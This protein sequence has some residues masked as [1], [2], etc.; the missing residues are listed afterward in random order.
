MPNPFIF[1]TKLYYTVTFP[2]FMAAY[3]IYCNH[4]YCVIKV[5]SEGVGHSIKLS[6]RM[7]AFVNLKE[8][9]QLITLSLCKWT[10][11]EHEMESMKFG[12]NYCGV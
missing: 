11:G 12:I 7:I 4:G 3:F 8:A 9:L 10:N 5:Y 1:Q 6:Q 2:Q